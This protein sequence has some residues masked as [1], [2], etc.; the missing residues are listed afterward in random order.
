MKIKPIKSGRDY[1]RML[2]HIETLMDAKPDS[3]EQDELLVA[4][5]IVRF[6]SK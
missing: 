4:N 3:R 5:R 1:R 6:C 2:A